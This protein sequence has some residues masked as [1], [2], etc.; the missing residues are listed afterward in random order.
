MSTNRVLISAD[1]L[2]A[3]LE[4]ERPPL[5]LDARYLGP[6]ATETGE[7]SFER[8]HIP[9]ARWVD[10]DRDLAGPHDATGGRHPLP[11][12][13]AFEEAM[14][15]LGVDNNYPVVVCDGAASLSAGRLWWMLTDA[16]HDDVRVLDGGFRAW[17]D[18][19]GEVEQG[20]S[21]VVSEGNF[22]ARPGHRRS[23][24]AAGVQAAS[25][26]VWDVRT[27]ERFRGDEE[28]IDP[29][30]G[31]IPGAR[32]L[33]SIENHHHEGT[34]KPLEDLE[35]NFAE[36]RPGDVVYCG[37]GVTAAQ[38]LVA[39]EAAGITDVALYAGSWSDWITDPARG[40]ERG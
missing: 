17:R 4:G 21:R 2:R 29:V 1:Q 37:S 39:M 34:F 14:Q 11:E 27:P 13:G 9:G 23:V 6:A 31:H 24:D 3:E 5:V 32:N 10:L 30:A 38:A 26:T 35:D 36:V 8:G 16:G 19:G 20:P 15:R 7:A 22:V 18:A 33:P 40:V 28:P 12:P 25:G